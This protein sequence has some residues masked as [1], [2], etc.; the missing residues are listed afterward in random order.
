MFKRYR[1]RATRTFSTLIAV[2]LA[3]I[4]GT[5]TEEVAGNGDSA[6]SSVGGYANHMTSN[7]TEVVM[8]H[9][10]DGTTGGERL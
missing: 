3:T 6:P 1:K 10:D 4:E 5:R 8:I 2:S 9:N 7:D